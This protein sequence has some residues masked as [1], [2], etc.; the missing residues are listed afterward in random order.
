MTEMS[1]KKR[2][3]LIKKVEEIRCG[4]ESKDLILSIPEEQFIDMLLW[5]IKEFFKSIS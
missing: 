2:M 1:E 4:L 5:S 3:S